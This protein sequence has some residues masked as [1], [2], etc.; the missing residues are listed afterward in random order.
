MLNF[1]IKKNGATLS[2]SFA[3]EGGKDVKTTFYRIDPNEKVSG[4]YLGEQGFPGGVEHIASVSGA[5]VTGNRLEFAIV[6]NHFVE[7]H[8]MKDHYFSLYDA[9]TGGFSWPSSFSPAAVLYEGTFGKDWTLDLDMY[10]QEQDLD[11]SAT[12]SV[13]GYGLK[14]SL[15]SVKPKTLSNVTGAVVS[16]KYKGVNG[17]A[18]IS[19]DNPGVRIIQAIVKPHLGII[20]VTLDIDQNA[21]GTIKFTAINPDGSSATSK[22]SIKIQ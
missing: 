19:E 20:E 18:Y 1:V 6:G 17:A 7:G 13:L 5:L 14:P 15:T 21:R 22:R 10:D 3:G 11:G 12:F 2:T 9:A 8:P 4:L 16:I